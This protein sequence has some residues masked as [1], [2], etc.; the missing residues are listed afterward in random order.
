MKLVELLRRSQEMLAA[1]HDTKERARFEVLVAREAYG[2]RRLAT[3]GRH[4]NVWQR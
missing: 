4:V 2:R 3:P 1:P